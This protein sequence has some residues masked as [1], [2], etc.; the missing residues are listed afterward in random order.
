MI[1]WLEWELY[2]LFLFLYL[3]YY[4]KLV[5]FISVGYFP[6]GT[7]DFNSIVSSKVDA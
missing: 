4:T 2:C 5:I 7:I 6:R 1:S 3:S